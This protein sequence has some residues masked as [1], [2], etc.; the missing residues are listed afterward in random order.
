MGVELIQEVHDGV[1]VEGGRAHHHVFLRLR[2]VR[3]VRTA[4]LLSLHPRERKLFE[5]KLT[6]YDI[7]GLK[8][9]RA[10][11][12]LQSFSVPVLSF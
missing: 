7:K 8:I 12:Q 6:C 5:L 11:H 1:G 2:P 10:D 4:E 9:Q 3:R